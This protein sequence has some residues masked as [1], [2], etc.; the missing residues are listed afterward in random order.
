MRSAFVSASADSGITIRI[1][2]VDDD[3]L[4]AARHVG[5]LERAGLAFDVRVATGEADLRREL[6]EFVPDVVLCEDRLPG[7]DTR[8][9]LSVV[10]E[11]APDTP[12]IVVSGTIGEE[13]A[14]GALRD[15]AVDYVFKKNLS[16]LPDAVTRAIED[17]R[18]EALGRVAEFEFNAAY[19]RVTA[20]LTNVDSALMSYSLA[21]GRYY[22]VSPAAK[23]VYGRPAEDFYHH[24]DAWHEY[25][26]PDDLGTF[27]ALQQRM[28]VEG[29][30]EDRYRVIHADGSV[31]WIEQRAKVAYDANRVPLRVDSVAA[32]IT[33]RMEAQHQIERLSRIRDVLSAVNSAI[34]RINEPAELREEACRIA[35]TVGG[36][37]IAMMVE[38]NADGSSGEIQA[39]IGDVS[40][41]TIEG[42]LER[43][44]DDP[45]LAAGVLASSLRMD[46]PIAEND[47]DA[48]LPHTPQSRWLVDSGIRAIASFPFTMDA[49]R[50]GSLLLGSYERDFFNEDE[51]ELL[52][53]LTNNLAFKLELAA[54]RERVN[55]LSYYDQLTGLPNRSF[56][57]ERLS[58]EIA[59]SARRG[60]RLALLVFD[61]RQFA[62]VN[63]TLGDAGGDQILQE[64]AR[65]MREQ[66]GAE[67]IARIAGDRFS[68]L[69]PELKV[70]KDVMSALGA[71]G[72]RLLADPFVLGGREIQL[73]AHVGCAVYPSDGND[74]KTMF[75]MAET[76]LKSAKGS[77]A[78]YRFYSADLN[79]RMERRIDLEARLQRAAF[80][81]QFVM[82]YQPKVDLTTRA[83]VGVEALLRWRDPKR[84]GHLIAPNEFIAVLEETGLIK[85]VGRWGIGEAVRQHRAWLEAGLVAPRI[86]VNVSALQFGDRDLV[87]DVADAL[88]AH[89]SDPGLDLEVTES[90]VMGNVRAAVDTLRAIHDLGVEIAIDDFGTGYS[91]LSYLFQLPISAL[92][93]DRSF[94]DGMT[95]N[96]SKTTIVST[97]VSLGRDLK[98]RVIAEGVETEEQAKLLRMLRCDEIQGFLVGR[99]MPANALARLLNRR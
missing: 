98:L 93:I 85:E 25:V 56:A 53:A 84:P 18:R 76:A 95:S 59:A 33:E 40:R 46:R 68:I 51:V 39:V 20:L 88:N 50:K 90:A 60:D 79:Q 4:A 66:I 16:R 32:D 54:K 47:I 87:G 86:A 1:V 6:P 3:P 19:E 65:R 62:Y 48:Q 13:R 34:V 9:V 74:A 81:Q 27:F 75:R 10:E 30:A 49:G 41:G 64:I 83:I 92:K 71:Q 44:F 7:F 96:E 14:A 70:L 72:V 11:L 23:R 21:E 82:Y 97:M 77:D 8:A 69:I 73:T 94:I 24:D 67:N 15:G 57:Q 52:A 22:Y 99:P 78:P 38:V 35:T 55:Y 36:L 12:V 89:P 5:E 43:L 31:H 63:S 58:Q 42:T 26:H 91:S 2:L 29:V 61:L 17:A 37:P 28:M 45:D 80:E